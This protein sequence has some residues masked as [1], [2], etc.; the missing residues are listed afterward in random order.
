MSMWK[1]DILGVLT[2]FRLCCFRTLKIPHPK[3]H[4]SL[5]S[6]SAMLF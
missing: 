2:A 5:N 4:F 3:Q 1:K 6:L